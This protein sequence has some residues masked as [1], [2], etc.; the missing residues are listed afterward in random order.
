MVLFLSAAVSHHLYLPQIKSITTT[1][2]KERTAIKRVLTHQA[3]KKRISTWTQEELMLAWSK[4]SIEWRKELGF[5]F[6]NLSYLQFRYIL[7]SGFTS[8]YNRNNYNHG[9]GLTYFR[10]NF[11]RFPY[12]AWQLVKILKTCRL[13]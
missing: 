10:S 3:T 2:K 1:T 5:W 13:V 4:H 8:K 7:N 9:I 12:F 6:I 11:L